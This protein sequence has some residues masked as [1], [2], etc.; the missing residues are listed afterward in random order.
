MNPLMGQAQYRA[1]KQAKGIERSVIRLS[2]NVR[3]LKDIGAGRSSYRIEFGKKPGVLYPKRIVFITP[4]VSKARVAANR[5]SEDSK[6][7]TYWFNYFSKSLDQMLIHADFQLDTK[8]VFKLPLQ[9]VYNPS[10]V[11][12][13][14]YTLQ[15]GVVQRVFFQILALD[16]KEVMINAKSRPRF[17]FLSHLSFLYEGKSIDLSEVQFE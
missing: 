13:S 2:G 7:V 6:S 14:F 11:Q 16:Q 1:I 17:V 8:Q 15:K 4:F 9:A 10:G 5:L 12:T 3:K